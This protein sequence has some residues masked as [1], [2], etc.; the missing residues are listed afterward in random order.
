MNDSNP[1]EKNS[2]SH[3]FLCQK[4]RSDMS[5]SSEYTDYCIVVHPDVV[6]PRLSL[7]SPD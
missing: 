6:R 4:N 5:T 3:A 1:A 7:M 2:E